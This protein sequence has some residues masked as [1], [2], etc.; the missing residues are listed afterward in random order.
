MFGVPCVKQKKLR[1]LPAMFAVHSSFM[2][3]SVHQ[4]HSRAP[5]NIKLKLHLQVQRSVQ[6][7]H[8]YICS[9]WK[10]SGNKTHMDLRIICVS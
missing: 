8:N 4:S 1:P 9:V 3:S 2:L 6:D 5:K 10:K 7:E